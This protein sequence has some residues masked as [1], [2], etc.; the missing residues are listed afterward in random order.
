MNNT[1]NIELANTAILHK[2]ELILANSDNRYEITLNIAQK[3][4]IN[5]YEKLHMDTTPSIKPI[6][7]VIIETQIPKNNKPLQ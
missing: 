3:A 5:L 6:I 1:S 7:Q 4:K 2:M